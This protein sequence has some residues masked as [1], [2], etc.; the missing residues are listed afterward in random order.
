MMRYHALYINVFICDI[1]LRPDRNFKI[2]LQG[3][4]AM[5]YN[6]AHVERRVRRCWQTKYK[7]QTITGI[8]VNL[9]GVTG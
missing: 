6:L 9:R 1:K 4:I 7:Q 5:A 2:L 3:V 8:Y